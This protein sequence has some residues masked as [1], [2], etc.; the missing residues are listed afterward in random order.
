MVPLP[1]S[2]FPLITPILHRRHTDTE[3][4]ESTEGGAEARMRQ[5]LGKL[6][7][8]R[9]GKPDVPRRTTYQATPGAGRHR[10]RQDGE[11]PVVR[12]SLSEN[13][14]GGAHQAHTPLEHAGAGHGQPG[15]GRGQGDAESARQVQE[16]TDQLRAT[17]TRLGHA[18]LAAGEALRTA[19]ARQEEAAGLRQALDAAEAALAQARAELAAS[20]GAGMELEQRRDTKRR[21]RSEAAERNGTAAHRKVGR[22]L[23][24]TNR[25]RD[26]GPASEPEPVKWWAAD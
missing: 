24:S 23:G 10:F 16:L 12:L 21:P 25:V 8:A 15:E 17:Q 22:P 20:A 1:E 9:P 19:Q 14:R 11:V 13:G 26:Q 4:A 3:G 6:G 7:T 5:A 18:E 2:P